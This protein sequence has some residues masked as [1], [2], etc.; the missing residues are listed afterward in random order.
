VAGTS[1]LTSIRVCVSV[2]G[3][4]FSLTSGMAVCLY[5]VYL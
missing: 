3:N 5:E 2:S 4:W 1:S